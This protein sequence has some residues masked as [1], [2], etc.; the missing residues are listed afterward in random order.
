MKYGKLSRQLTALA[1]PIF[2]ETLLVMMLGAVD[3][4][5]LSRH[6]DNSVAAVGVVNQLMNLVF[7]LF[8]VISLGTSILCSQYF[9]AKRR[10][11]VI[12][13]VG[14]SLIFNLLSG[15]ILSL[16]L[17][18]FAGDFLHMMG[19]RPDLMSEGLPY[20]KIVGGFAF[21]Q[22]ISLSL[23][24]SLRSANKAKYPMYVSV[25]VNVLNIIGNYTLIFGKFG[26]PALGVEGAA[27]STSICRFVSVVLLFIILF[28][29]HIPSFP[30]ELF[31][32]FPWIEL[33][34]LLK[35]G[36][37]SAGEHM[38]YSLSQ[39][40]IAYFINMISN[41]ALAT[42]TYIVNIVMFTYIFALALAQGGAILIGQLVGMKKIRAAYTIGK[43]VMRV[44][45]AFSVTLSLL[46]AI[47][48]KTI[49]SMLTSDPWIISTGATILWVE[50]FLENGRALNFFGVNALRSAGDIYF[51]VILGIIV[52]WGVQVVGSYILG[53][54][55]GW[56]L[57]AMWAIFA[58]DENIRGF[59]FL[60]RWNSFKWVGKGFVK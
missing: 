1:G 51:P 59:I 2:I 11:K 9:G 24:A 46:V 58:L 33:K 39:V 35:I 41:E 32:P 3:T 19:L 28:K 14:I 22:A 60:H 15:L 50:I 31:R 47:F 36:I 27:I 49:L 16:C 7:L 8:E 45:V 10:D 21:L 34:N 44:G 57:I 18:F 42:R 6:S 26:M 56:G 43:R 25:V 4:F 13:V 38:S 54:T 12:Q 5:M 17:Y 23:S 30:K 52:M 37:P 40:V 53:I 55:L 48:G 29:K 20:M